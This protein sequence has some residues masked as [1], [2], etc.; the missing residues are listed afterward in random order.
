M[1]K[2]ARNRRALHDVLV[3]GTSNRD[4]M[5]SYSLDINFIHSDINGRSCKK[6]NFVPDIYIC[7][8][9]AIKQ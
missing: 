8:P 5:V 4:I 6:D 9:H 2:T 1:P 3:Q 7:S